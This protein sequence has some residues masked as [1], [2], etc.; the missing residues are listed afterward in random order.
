MAIDT[1]RYS[2]FDTKEEAEEGFAFVSREMDPFGDGVEQCD[3]CKKWGIS[4]FYDGA[5][6]SAGENSMYSRICYICNDSHDDEE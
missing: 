4:S 6:E 5:I 3:A 1:E 2:L